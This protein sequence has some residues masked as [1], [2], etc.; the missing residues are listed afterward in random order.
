MVI[1]L[2]RGDCPHVLR[3][4]KSLESETRAASKGSPSRSDT[5]QI[6]QSRNK[7]IY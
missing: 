2:N 6:V 1:R 5:N 4:K 3:N 7:A